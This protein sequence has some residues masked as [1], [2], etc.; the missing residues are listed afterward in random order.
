MPAGKV[1]HEPVSTLDIAPTLFDLSGAAPLLPQHGQSLRP[2]IETDRA[3]RD[4]AMNEWDLLPNRVGVAMS[5]RCV[6]TRT[7]KLAMDMRSGSGELYDLAADPDEMVNLF[8]DAAHADVQARL[9]GYLHMRPDDIT[10][11]RVPVGPA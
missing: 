1:V 6:R 7:H 5:L 4:F 9:T 8:D 2:L 10:P 3:K 11:N